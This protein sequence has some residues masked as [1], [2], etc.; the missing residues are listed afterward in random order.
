MTLT[1]DL[2]RCH[3]HD[4]SS[5]QIATIQYILKNPLHNRKNDNID[6]T[7]KL[8]VIILQHEVRLHLYSGILLH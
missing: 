5:M 2:G 4:N 1:L 8:L 6:L 3:L 7:R